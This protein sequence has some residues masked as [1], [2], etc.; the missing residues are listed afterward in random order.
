MKLPLAASAADRRVLPEGRLAGP[1]P[2][3]IAIMMALTVLAA[4]AGLGLAHAAHRFTAELSDRIS[5][6]VVEADPAARE[7]QASAVERVLGRAP[8]VAAVHRLG[9]GEIR[10]LLQPWLGRNLGSIDLPVP[11]LI[12]ADLRPG[13]RAALPPLLAAI[14]RASPAA[15]VDDHA[16]WLAPLS[17]LL[18]TLIWLSVALVLLMAGATA[19]VVA[20]ASRG[21]LNTH[22]ATIEVLHLMGGTDVQVARLF[23]RRIALD[24]LF[25]SLVGLAGAAAVLLLLGHEVRRTGS[26]LVG[27][28][29]LGIGGWVILLLLPLAATL[30]ATL[31][32][33]WTV[34]AALRRLL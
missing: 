26:A 22:R 19:A 11:A 29:G 18:S 20:L 5:V 30:L 7:A 2:Y 6:Q 3:V 23:Q 9:E 21:A 8:G 33:R 15:R 16:G 10:R 24:A 13:G 1:M 4:A 34:L 17:G 25:G 27:A 12:D 28:I 14:R 31:T 32:A